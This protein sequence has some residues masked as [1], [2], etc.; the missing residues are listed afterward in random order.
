MNPK[1]DNSGRGLF[2]GMLITA[3][4][5]LAVILGYLSRETLELVIWAIVV[6]AFLR[7]VGGHFVAPALHYMAACRTHPRARVERAAPMPAPRRIEREPRRAEPKP[8]PRTRV[9]V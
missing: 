7:V 8:M 9:V 4:L 3:G 6:V 1:K 2:L 5:A